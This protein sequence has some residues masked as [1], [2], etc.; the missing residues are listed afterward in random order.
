MPP[1]YDNKKVL[2]ALAPYPAVFVP[3]SYGGF[4]VIFPNFAKG[5]AQGLTLEQAYKEARTELSMLLS[6]AF[7]DGGEPPRP[8]NPEALQ[9]DEDEIPGTRIVM[10][11]PEKDVILKRLGLMKKERLRTSPSGEKYKP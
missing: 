8:S 2:R 11:E 3:T 7:M 6:L 10:I 4:E 1:K 5:R 9:P